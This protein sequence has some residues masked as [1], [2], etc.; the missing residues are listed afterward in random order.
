[1]HTW[2]EVPF[3]TG[4]T[5]KFSD[6]SLCQTPTW[7]VRVYVHMYVYTHAYAILRRRCMHSPV[8]VCSNIHT[9][10]RANPS[11]RPLFPCMKVGVAATLLS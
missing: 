8:H 3:T 4:C 1:M 7:Y 6:D 10:R 9:D 11:T 2:H 5:F